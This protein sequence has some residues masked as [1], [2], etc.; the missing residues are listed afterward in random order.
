MKFGTNWQKQ[1]SKMISS[2][3]IFVFALGLRAV[4]GDRRDDAKP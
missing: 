2:F 3:W 4:A 1:K